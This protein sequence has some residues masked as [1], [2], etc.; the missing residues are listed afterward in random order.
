MNADSLDVSVPLL[1]GDAPL[2]LRG[3]NPCPFSTNRDAPLELR[4]DIS[5]YSVYKSQIQKQVL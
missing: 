1:V 5:N 4:C 3:Y 2:E